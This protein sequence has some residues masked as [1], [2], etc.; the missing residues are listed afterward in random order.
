[1]QQ[2]H[3]HLLWHKE[4]EKTLAS[5]P[6]ISSPYYTS[7]LS[8]CNNYVG[9]GVRS[10]AA[11]F[12]YV[13]KT[14]C[15]SPVLSACWWHRHEVHNHYLK[16]NRLH[17]FSILGL[18]SS[19]FQL[20]RAYLSSSSQQQSVSHHVVGPLQCSSGHTASLKSLFLSFRSQTTWN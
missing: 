7:H 4:E 11:S 14:V 2:H 5:Y 20:C 13:L 19:D 9:N 15:P 1:M 17:T 18:K 12:L 3:F 8:L 6:Q 16:L 10:L